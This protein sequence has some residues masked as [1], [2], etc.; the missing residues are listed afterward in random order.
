MPCNRGEVGVDEGH[1][2]ANSKDKTIGG[3]QIEMLALCKSL[4]TARR[5]VVQ[6]SVQ[7]GANGEDK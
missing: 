3:Q 1:E 2:R 6:R 4:L 5:K 7:S